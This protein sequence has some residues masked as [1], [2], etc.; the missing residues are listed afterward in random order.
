MSRVTALLSL[1]TF[2]VWTGIALPFYMQQTQVN[3]LLLHCHYNI[4]LT[5]SCTHA[6]NTIFTTLYLRISY[7]KTKNKNNKK[8]LYVD[9]W[10]VSQ[11]L[12]QTPHK[13]R[14]DKVP[15][16]PTCL[17]RVS[18][19]QETLGNKMIH[20]LDFGCMNSSSVASLDDVHL[21]FLGCLKPQ[22]YKL[23]IL[24]TDHFT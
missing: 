2:M 16:Q 20:A 1:Y 18:R 12:N 7:R 8:N 17:V 14:P 24:V 5:I 22:I 13:Y 19:S 6:H 11:N 4:F 10:C 15:L 3:S 21:F 23:K 9:S